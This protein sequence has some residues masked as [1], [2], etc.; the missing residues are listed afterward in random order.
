MSREYVVGAL[1]ARRRHPDRITNYGVGVV[2][3][4]EDSG[5]AKGDHVYGSLRK[6]VRLIMLGSLLRLH[7]LLDCS[8]PGI[9]RPEGP[10]FAEET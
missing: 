5:Y 9:Y 2:L 3:R 6:Q 1:M 8:L 7:N 10:V 4:S